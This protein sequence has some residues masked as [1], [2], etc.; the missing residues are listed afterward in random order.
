LSHGAV[1]IVLE[2]WRL[3]DCELWAIFPTGRMVSAKARAFL[4]FIEEKLRETIFRPGMT[5]YPIA[6]LDRSRNR[7]GPPGAQATLHQN[8]RFAE[9]SMARQHRSV[10]TDGTR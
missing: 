1:R 3:P 2:E 7:N 9:K 10:I 6:R 5:E 4:A 8:V